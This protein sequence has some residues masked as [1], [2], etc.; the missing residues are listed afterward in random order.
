VLNYVIKNRWL[1]LEFVDTSTANV[2]AA[3]GPPNT[4]SLDGSLIYNAL[5]DSIVTN[6]GD[7]GWGAVGM[8]LTGTF[9]LH[10]MTVFHLK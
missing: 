7:T 6:F 9:I 8:S 10:N 2:S 1:L 4:Q 5:R 3:K